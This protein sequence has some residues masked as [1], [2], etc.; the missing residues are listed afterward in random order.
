MA[1]LLLCVTHLFCIEHDTN[2]R[3]TFIDWTILY[4]YLDPLHRFYVMG[5]KYVYEITLYD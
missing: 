3:P 2:Y 4:T 1:F 5:M